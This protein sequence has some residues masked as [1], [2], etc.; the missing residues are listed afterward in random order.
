MTEI[1]NKA[2]KS[3]SILSAMWNNGN[4]LSLILTTGVFEIITKVRHYKYHLL[5]RL[6]AAA[7]GR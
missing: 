5:V 2:G 6:G 7:L 3:S 4:C 1:L